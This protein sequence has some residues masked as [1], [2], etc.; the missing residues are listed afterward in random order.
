M[1]II[2]NNDSSFNVESEAEFINQLGFIDAPIKSKIEFHY[3][4][5]NIFH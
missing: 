4:D 5:G 1:F 2:I 3:Q